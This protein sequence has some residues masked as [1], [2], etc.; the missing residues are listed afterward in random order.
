VRTLENFNA[1]VETTSLTP[2]GRERKLYG[3]DY[4]WPGKK[5]GKAKSGRDYHLINAPGLLEGLLKERTNSL[6]SLFAAQ[7]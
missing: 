2:N 7:I 5:L 3:W 4:F 6:V 1:F